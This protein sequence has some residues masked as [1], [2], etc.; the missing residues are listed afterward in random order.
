MTWDV[1]IL[2]PVK[3][4]LVQIGNFVSGLVFVLIIIVIG[5]LIAKLIKAVVERFLSITPLDNI[6]KEAKI[7]E[8]LKKGGVTSSVA[9]LLGN[10]CYWLVLLITAV[11]AVNAI[12]LS[13]AADLLNQIILYIP[14]VVAAVFI[15]ILGLFAATILNSIVQ[16]IVANAGISQ[17]KLLGKIVE[18]VTVVFAVI[19]A[20]EQLQIAGI[21]M[22][23]RIIL[24]VL[25]S[26]GLAVGLAFGLGCKDIA[27]KFISD[28]VE[29][30]KSKK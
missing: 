7:D 12:G 11:L 19:I 27:G 3:N 17:A 20:L 24:I 8:I 16:T 14:N 13:T 6:V 29:K 18:V 22:L 25:A 23:E 30:V 21:L 2:E 9:E 28:L 10:I 15:L 4:V 1:V 5:W 26:L